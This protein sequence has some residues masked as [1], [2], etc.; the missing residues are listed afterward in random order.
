MK[1]RDSGMPDEAYWETLLDVEGTLQ[2]F[3]IGQYKDVAEMGCG[4][5]TFSYPIAKA[6]SGTLFAFDIDR[7]MINRTEQRLQGLKAKCQVRDV[8]E[9]GFGVQVDVVLLFNILHCEAPLSL[10]AHAAKAANRVL[11]THWQSIAT[12]RGPSLDIR[13][14]PEQIENW[15]KQVGFELQSC[16][17]LPPWHFG[18]ELVHRDDG[19]Q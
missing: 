15:A 11:V 2:R 1:V 3:N 12:P 6:I 18:M 17:S 19:R 5:G 8:V 13:P 7:S 10:L 14:T 16:F 4:Y 9:L